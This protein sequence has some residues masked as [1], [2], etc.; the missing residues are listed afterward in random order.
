MRRIL[1][2]SLIFTVCLNIYFSG[3][4]LGGIWIP[5]QSRGKG[6]D[7]NHHRS[8]RWYLMCSWQ[9]RHSER[10]SYCVLVTI[11]ETSW[12]W[13]VNI[14]IVNPFGQRYRERQNMFMLFLIII[15]ITYLSLTATIFIH[16]HL[17][18]NEEWVWIVE[19]EESLLFSHCQ[20]KNP[21]IIQIF[22]I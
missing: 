2:L 4:C 5:I 1:L 18:S 9:A 10:V 11:Y 14:R 17:A 6:D 20:H 8:S 19:S 21:R 7:H 13:I 16:F 15:V 22:G 12:P 3:R